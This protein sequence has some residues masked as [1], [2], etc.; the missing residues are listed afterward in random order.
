MSLAKPILIASLFAGI[1]LAARAAAPVAVTLAIDTQHPAQQILGYGA[2]GAWWAQDVGGLPESQRREILR[3]LYDKKTGIGLTI[4]RHNLGAGTL[5]DPT[6]QKGNR[7]ADSML[8]PKTGRI[9]WSRDA[10]ARRIMREAVDAGAE[11]IILFVNSP[12]VIMTINGHGRCT[13]DPNGKFTNGKLDPKTVK[14]VTNLAPERYAD[15]AAYLGEVTER[16]LRTDKLPIVAVSPINEPGHPW[17]M[18]KQEGC[19]YSPDQ[20]AAL[21]KVILAEFKRRDLPVRIEPTESE[22]WAK[23][24]PYY[25]AII[26]DPALRAALTDYCVHSYDSYPQTKQ[27]LR[28]WFD[29]N[30]PGARLHM[31]E[32]CEMRLKGDA[33]DMN[34]GA[35][36]LARTMIEDLTIGRAVTWQYWKAAATFGTHDSL[37]YYNAKTGA[38]TP[39]KLYWVM[40]QFTRYIPKGSV[41]LAVKTPADSKDTPAL[42][43]RLPDGRVAV[44]SVNLSETDRTLDFKFPKNE[45]WRPQLRAITDA[46]NNNTVTSGGAVNNTL[47]AH[48]VVT[49]IFQKQP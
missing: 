40:G 35:L 19:Y 42:A 47:P 27:K 46:K 43:A 21:L 11:Q 5:N 20:T 16:F 10:N 17:Q 44:V 33:R 22:S 39:T 9:D 8:D 23:A 30:C 31:S 6:I 28:D 49:I 7:R 12:P 18:D 15:F 34:N 3:L 13:T 1:M 4:Y 14:A 48:S 38:V 26:R 32:W 25:A 29:K 45:I 36:P 24:I 41:I 37:L 2:T